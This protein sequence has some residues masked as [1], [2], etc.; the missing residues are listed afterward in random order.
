MAIDYQKTRGKSTFLIPVGATGRTIKIELQ[1]E[2]GKVVAVRRA[3]PEHQLKQPPAWA[4]NEEVVEFFEGMAVDKICIQ[5]EDKEWRCSLDLFLSKGVWLDRGFGKQMAL[6]LKYWNQ[7]GQEI[8]KQGK[9]T[10]GQL[11]LFT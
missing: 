8:K 11:Q 10:N 5:C 1:E 9:E 4:F 3:L 6:P 2:N 7:E